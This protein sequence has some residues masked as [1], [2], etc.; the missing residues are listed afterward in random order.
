[1]FTLSQPTDLELLALIEKN[2]DAPF[3]YSLLDGYRMDSNRIRLGEGRAVFER[4]LRALRSWRMF[5]LGWVRIFPSDAEI[6]PG[7]VVAVVVSH[8][9]FWSVNLAR[10]V[11][12]E[13]P[14]SFTYGTL[15]EHAASG[16]ERFTVR[17]DVRDDSVWYEIQAF[18]RPNHW[19]AKAGYPLARMLQKRFARDS[20]A[21]M[22]RC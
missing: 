17:H 20:M 16:E 5:D 10:I 6:R 4:A 7:V 22:R 18:S 11:S 15:G 8:F 3:S 19:L 2:K 12:A 9:G 13:D 14:G 21:A 1:M